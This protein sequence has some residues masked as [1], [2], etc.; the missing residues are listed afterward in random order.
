MLCYMYAFLEL[1]YGGETVNSE[2]P[3]AFTCPYCG[4]M[5][6]TESSIHEHVTSDHADTSYEVVSF[7][8][9]TKILK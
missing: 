7:K 6:F 2:S 1:F 4:K 8:Q 5:G 3:Q 9:K